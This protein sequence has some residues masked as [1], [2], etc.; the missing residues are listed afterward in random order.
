MTKRNPA[1]YWDLDDDARFEI[2]E[3][4]C[5]YEM[6]GWA[7]WPDHEVKRIIKEQ[8]PNVDDTTLDAFQIRFIDEITS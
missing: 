6:A 4:L 7:G 1:E 3:K 5:H 8:W 2:A